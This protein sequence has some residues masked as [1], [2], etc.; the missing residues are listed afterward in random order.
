MRASGSAVAPLISTGT[1]NV[2]Y[3]YVGSTAQITGPALALNTWYHIAVSRTSGSTK[4]YLN[5]VQ[6]GS[7]YSDSNS[8]VTQASRPIMGSYG[9][10]VA[11]R[12]NG[13]LSNLRVVNQSMYSA[14]FTPP[15][16]PF[17][18][19]TNTSLLLLGTNTGIQDATGK[20][21]I[22]NYGTS[23]TQANTVKFGSG[24][25]YFDGS[26]G[27][28]QNLSASNKQLFAFGSGNFTVELWVYPLSQGGHG[29]TNNDCL[30]DFRNNVSGGGGV[31]G[32]LYSYSNGTGVN[33]YV[34]GSVAISG[35]AISNNTW[36]HIAVSR[37]GTSTKLFI[38][39]T[40]AGSTFS[41][42]TVYVASPI[43]IGQFYDGTGG[44]YFNGYLDDIRVTNG[45]ARYTAN[46]TPP[47]IPDL[48]Q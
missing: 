35:S 39:G 2:L 32:T 26:T 22:I 40:Q 45:I 31:C 25:M 30:I 46:F 15:S 34:N 4:M 18:P 20:N 36:T 5:G 11:N 23:K 42:S 14:N 47:T 28:L 27:Y 19:S 3:Y 38:N 10:T 43:T 41:D 7:T 17:I 48:T 24:A 9:D 6:V 29:S 37:S 33:W 12:F 1:S 8:Y 44:G 13:Y 16:G 21:N